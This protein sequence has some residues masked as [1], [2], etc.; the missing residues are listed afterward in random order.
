MENYRKLRALLE[1]VFDFAATATLL[2]WDQQ[3]MMPPGGTEGRARARALINRVAHD[4]F[5]SAEMEDT[6]AAARGDVAGLDPDSDEARIVRRASI[7]FEKARR[8]PSEWVSDLFHAATISQQIWEEAKPLSDFDKFKPHLEKIVSLR[9]DYADFFAPYDHIYDPLLDDF[10][11]G[12][13]TTHIAELFGQLRQRQV[14]LVRSIIERGKPVNAAPLHRS[15]PLSKQEAFS[16]EVAKVLGYDMRCGRIDVAVHPFTNGLNPGDVRITTRYHPRYVGSALFSTIHESGHAMYD[17]GIP[18]TMANIPTFLGQALT[19]SFASSMGVHESQSR[20]WENFVGRGHPFWKYYYPRLKKIFPSPLQGVGLEAFYRA[21]NK[22]EPSFIRTEA[23]EATYNL[24]I[25][26]RF[27]LETSLM[28][29]SLE[30]SDLPEAWSAKMQEYIGL[31]PPDHE[32]GVLQ[33]IHWSIGYIGYFPSYTLGN[34]MAG[35]LWE[36][37]SKDLPSLTGEFERGEFGSLLSWLRHNV[38]AHGA[39]YDSGELMQRST[40]KPLT[41]EPYLQYLESKFGEIYKL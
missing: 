21:I 27:D 14:H 31:T 30:A 10:E 34:L 13:K 7:D 5:I 3:T 26:L 24:H 25:M 16:R 35:Q 36:K 6:L 23:D 40:G 29:R 18:A 12:M 22:V 41:A 8:V 15:Y 20:M 4:R 1:E 38:H 11:P 2:E 9:R 33:D 32:R 37:I 17:Q 19:P 28:T 39:K